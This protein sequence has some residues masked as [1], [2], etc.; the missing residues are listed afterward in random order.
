[1]KWQSLEHFLAMGGYALYVWGSYAVTVAVVA[2]EL[3]L[4]RARTKAARRAAA[5]APVPGDDA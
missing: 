4:L 1:M 3:A 2:L 5:A